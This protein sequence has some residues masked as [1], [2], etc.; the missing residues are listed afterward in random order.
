MSKAQTPQGRGTVS[1]YPVRSASLGEKNLQWV[2]EDRD[3]VSYNPDSS[4]SGDDCH[5][6]QWPSFYKFPLGKEACNPLWAT[7]RIYKDIQEAQGVDFSGLYAAL[8]RSFFKIEGLIRSASG[9]T[10]VRQPSVVIS[11]KVIFPSW[12]SPHPVTV[13]CRSIKACSYWPPSP[14][15]PPPFFRFHSCWFQE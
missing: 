12:G 7:P 10:P 1:H 11:P 9:G 6:S 15:A 14:S 5:L 13:Q 8:P 3:D 2:V 4:C